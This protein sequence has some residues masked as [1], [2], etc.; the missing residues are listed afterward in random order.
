MARHSIL[1]SLLLPLLFGI[2]SALSAQKPVVGEAERMLQLFARSYTSQGAKTE[3]QLKTIMAV[4][5]PGLTFEVNTVALSGNKKSRSGDVTD[6]LQFLRRMHVEGSSDV[7]R[8]FKKME[9]IH[10][11]SHT[12]YANIHIEFTWQVKGKDLVRGDEHLS[13]LLRKVD[14]TQWRIVDIRS[15]MIET[16]KFRGTCLC[17]I[18]ASKASSNVS[19]K[20]T[21][22]AG[23]NYRA[24]TV[25][26]EIQECDPRQ[27]TY[28]IRISNYEFKWMATGQLYLLKDDKQCGKSVIEPELIGAAL[29]QK[30]A[31]G[32]IIRKYLFEFECAQ[33]TFK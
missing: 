25:V 24:S 14:E 27:K 8:T 29:E 2:C 19:A 21:M 23:S 20:I 30:E 9:T 6:W 12:I 22:P 4:T 17:E 3:E 31:L 26:F 7:V 32:I 5:D 18:F 15:L 10:Q 11:R 33:I 13:V 1:Q 16:E 28:L